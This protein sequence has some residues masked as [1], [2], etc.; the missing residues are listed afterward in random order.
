[1]KS[2][3]TLFC[4]ATIGAMALSTNAF[5]DGPVILARLNLSGTITVNTNVSGTTRGSTTSL[6]PYKLSFN[7]R[8]IVSLLNA[9]TNFQAW[10]L[11]QTGSISNLPATTTFAYDIYNYFIW[12]VLPK[13]SPLTNV[14]MQ[15]FDSAT[16]Y[17]FFVQ[18]DIDQMSSTFS[19]NTI[20]GGGSEQDQLSQWIIEIN[21]NMPVPTVIYAEGQMNLNWS[22]SPVKN[23]TQKLTVSA[24]FSGSGSS[25]LKGW[26]GTDTV[27]ASG[28][29]T[30]AAVPSGNWPFWTWWN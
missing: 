7:T 16:N 15:G 10:L 30:A 25:I 18:M 3:K 9:S 2:I 8:N 19:L 21:D 22:A 27:K 13:G 24:N 6:K 12:A 4:A 14:L 1:M 11:Y 26:L 23:E 29:G 5:A 17:D 20:T 28:S